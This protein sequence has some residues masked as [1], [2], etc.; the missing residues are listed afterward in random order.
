[1]ASQI[2]LSY[3]TNYVLIDF[4]VLLCFIQWWCRKKKEMGFGTLALTI[5]QTF[6]FILFFIRLSTSPTKTHYCYFNFFKHTQSIACHSTVI[7]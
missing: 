1:M 6:Y 3:G 2:I 5:S 4:N 7:E